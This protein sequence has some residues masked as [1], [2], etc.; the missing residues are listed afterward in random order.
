MEYGYKTLIL[1]DNSASVSMG[2]RDIINATLKY[3]IKNAPE[4]DSFALATYSGQTELLVDFDREES[5][6]ID[7]IDRIEYTEKVTCLNDVLMDTVMNWKNSDFAMRNILLITDGLGDDSTVY[8]LE[9]VYFTLNE[10]AYPVYVIALSQQTNADALKTIASI[11]RISHG[12]VFFTE[13]DDSEAEVERKLSEKI[14]AAMEKKRGVMSGNE[15]A[16][17]VDGSEEQEGIS[18]AD[19]VQEDESYESQEYY[20]ENEEIFDGGTLSNPAAFISYTPAFLILGAGLFMAVVA[21]ILLFGKGRKKPEEACRWKGYDRALTTLRDRPV[22]IT[23]ED[24][25]NPMRFFRLPFMEHI[26]IGGSRNDSQ[27]TI[28]HDE[29][30]NDRHCEINFHYGKYFLKDLSSRCGTF[31]NG[32]RLQNETELHSADVITVGRAKLMIRMLY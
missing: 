28:D 7:A 8:P 29:D 12:G 27:V 22:E 32:E 24:L 6:Y 3:L 11:G 15:K 13:F 20:G 31:L 17:C 30:V 23:I 25:N 16:D 10:N 1:L 26:V 2:S 4:T 19:E 14:F 5:A 21:I 9:E 18:G